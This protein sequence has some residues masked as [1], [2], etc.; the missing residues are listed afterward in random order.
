MDIQR[1]IE[2]LRNELRQHNHNYYVLDRPV[3]SD[4]EFDMKLKELQELEEKHPEFQDANSPTRRVGG[5]VTKNFET[6]QHDYR[7]YSLD[8]SY[9]K[10]DL[11]ELGKTH[12]TDFGRCRW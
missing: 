1:Q 10:E 7:M 8:N 5:A 11:E 9:S 3:I 6:V 4:Y 2:S 12:S